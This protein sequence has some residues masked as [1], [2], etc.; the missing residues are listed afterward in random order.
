[1][2]IRSDHSS[3]E[4]TNPTD[5]TYFC[6][7]GTDAEVVINRQARPTLQTGRE[8][9][10]LA[11]KLQSHDL[12]SFFY[13]FGLQDTITRNNTNSILHIIT[14]LST[15]INH[16]IFITTNIYNAMR[17]QRFVNSIF[18]LFFKIFVIKHFS[19]NIPIFSGVIQAFSINN[20]TTFCRSFGKAGNFVI[21]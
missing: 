5:L 7:P 9:A 20:N 14:F 10:P 8:A 2:T 13:K 19:S 15:I 16:I 3:P 11:S 21:L 12:Y 17:M 18:F 4:A 1:M 6:P